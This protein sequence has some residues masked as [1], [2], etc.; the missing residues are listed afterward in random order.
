MPFSG[1]DSGV[2]VL[3]ST[4]REV[5]YSTKPNACRT[6]KTEIYL[7]MNDQL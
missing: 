5:L 1:E 4:G 7:K 3:Q 2:G 6:N